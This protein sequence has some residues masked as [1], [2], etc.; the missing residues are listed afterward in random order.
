M[1]L[2]LCGF[3]NSSQAC[4]VLFL[5][6]DWFGLL[7]IFNLLVSRWCYVLLKIHLFGDWQQWRARLI[8]LYRNYSGFLWV[9]FC[10]CYEIRW[11]FMGYSEAW[12]FRCNY[13]LLLFWEATL[14]WLKYCNFHG[15]SYPRSELILVLLNYVMFMDSQSCCKIALMSTSWEKHLEACLCGWIAPGSCLKIWGLKMSCLCCTLMAEMCRLYSGEHMGSCYKTVCDSNSNNW[16][17]QHFSCTVIES[18]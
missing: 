11:C 15:H 3:L 16:A 2:A 8:L 18:T 1:S 4:R 14:S 6:C 13:G 17:R 10:N 12:N 7:A 5:L 9:R